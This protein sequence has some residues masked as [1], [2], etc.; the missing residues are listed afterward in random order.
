MQLVVSIA[1]LVTASAVPI[2]PHSLALR[3][4]NLVAVSLN[5]TAEAAS[6]GNGKCQCIGLDQISGETIVDVAGSKVSYPADL[7][8]RCQAW[9]DDKNPSCKAGQTPGQ[10]KDWCAQA[11]CYVDPCK[12][13]IPVSPKTSSYLPNANYQGKPVYYSYETCGATDLWTATE[14]KTACVNQAT[15]ADCLKGD[16]CA[17][18]GK[19]CGGAEVMGACSKKL[20]GFKFG[21]SNC[22]C[23]GI[24]DQPGT[25]NM[26]VGN[27]SIAYPADAGASCEAW[28]Q[29][30]NPDCQK[31]DAPAWCFQSW[32]YVDPCTCKSTEAPALSS[33]LPDAKFQGKPIYYS[34]GTCG[35]VD[36]WTA[37]NHAEACI[38]QKSEGDC[39][40]L[41][42]KCSWTGKECLGKEAAG[43]CTAAPAE[44]P[45]PK[46]GAWAATPLAG[47]AVCLAA[48]A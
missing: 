34:Y 44:P 19:K 5:Q 26:K 42:G 38:N 20:H 28:D 41:S 7:G 40:K 47:L 31:P 32:C 1:L 46:A 27:A 37:A 35:S 9:D 6:Y 13:D 29:N 30:R 10:G 2:R 17:W 43:A 18:D 12:C 23:I 33:Y 39:G 48:L 36:T 8:A 15:K 21:R 24:D 45:A 16:K 14:H 11:W 4:T 22:R 3:Q 25:T